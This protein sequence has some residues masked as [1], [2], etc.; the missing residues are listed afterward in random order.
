MKKVI[1]IDKLFENYMRA[2]VAKTSGKYTEDEWYDK[3]PDIYAEFENTTFPELGGYT[4]ATYYDDEPELVALWL[5]YVNSGTPLNDYLIDAIVKS[6]PEDG[7]IAL[8]DENADEEVLL[9]A[10]EILRRKQSEKAV[11]RYIDLLFAKKVCHHV[12]DEMTEDV[13][14]AVDK[15]V[16][17]LL[18]KLDGKPV[19]SRF[20]E[21]LSHS[22]KKDERIKRILLDGLK[23]GDK[24][25]EYAVYLTNYDDESCLGEMTDYLAEVT[26]YVSYKELKIAIEALGGFVTEERDFSS[27]K[28]YIRIKSAK[29]DSDKD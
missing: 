5:K 9:S 12:K 2:Y 4:P 7:I 18:E 14:D 19:N 23:K 8:L 27:D 13:I 6:V 20:A 10:V 26:D 24:V 17:I 21:I 1:D 15:V 29:D 11:Y 28:N 22:T 25:P 16:D 3:L